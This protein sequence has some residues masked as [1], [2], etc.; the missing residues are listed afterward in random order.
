MEKY[1]DIKFLEKFGTE[2]GLKLI[3]AVMI[4]YIGRIIA[5]I[6]TRIL[7]KAMV[8][9]KVDSML[10]SFGG[11]ILHTILLILIVIASLSQLGI[12]TTH[13]AAAIAAAGLAVGLALQG[14]LSNFASGVLIIIYR[15]FKIGDYI[16]VSGSEGTVKD[17]SILTTTLLTTDNRRVVIP[18]ANITGNNLVNF[19]A[20]KTRMIDLVISISHDDEIEAARGVI[21]GVMA[22]DTRILTSPEPLIAVKDL[23]AGGVDLMVRPWVKTEDYFPTM[24]DLKEKIREAF[25]KEGI[26]AALPPFSVVSSV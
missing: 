5:R 19:S 26:K 13:I 7:K 11:N 14:S 21:K 4:F 18:N 16:Q 1:I 2:Y 12:E 25:R 3:G 8:R 17:I 22:S 24:F 15:P 20:E 23:T 9:A 6:L 10:I